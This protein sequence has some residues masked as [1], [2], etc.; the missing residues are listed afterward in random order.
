[1]GG[2][3][4]RHLPRTGPFRELAQLATAAAACA[5]GSSSLASSSQR[6][7]LRL[8]RSADVMV[9]A[10]P[11]E[12]AG[13]GAIQA[14]ACGTPGG[15]GRRRPADAVIDGTTGL[16]IAPEHPACWRTACACCW[17]GR[18]APGVRHR[19]RRPGS[20]PVL[21]AA[22]RPGD[23][24]GL[25]AVPARRPLRQRGSCRGR[26]RRSRGEPE[27]H[28]WPRSPS[29]GVR[30]SR[31]RGPVRTAARPRPAQMRAG[32]GRQPCLGRARTLPGR[33]RRQTGP[34]S[35]PAAHA[36]RRHACW[37]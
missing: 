11:Y 24:R 7:W 10:S 14:M 3:D 34:G 35:L 17:H 6:R 9:S 13:I 20:V 33:V 16:L 25:R 4:A 26:A 1:M 37:S 27:L 5:A 31:L 23:C 18:S 29:G 8:L 12:P 30:I 22:H 32:S 28:R 19:R 15:L 21:G 36:P 2:P